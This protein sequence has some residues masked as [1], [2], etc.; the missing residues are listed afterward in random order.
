[1]PGVRLGAPVRRSP[2]VAIGAS[3]AGRYCLKRRLLV[4][5][6]PCLSTRP[7]PCQDIRCPRDEGRTI[8]TETIP[9]ETILCATPRPGVLLV[10]LNR[11]EKRNALNVEMLAALAAA[12][13]GARDDNALRC[14]ESLNFEP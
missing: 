14:A 11:P 7:W 6:P 12:L 13:E 10:I 1:M 9:T 4:N 2:P 5:A 3:R 8:L